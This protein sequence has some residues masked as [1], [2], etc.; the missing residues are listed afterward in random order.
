MSKL[1]RHQLAA[2][3]AEKSLSGM[4]ARQLGEET[5]AYLLAEGRTGELDSLLRD[6]MQY[7]ADNGIVEVVAVS[8]RQLNDKARRNVEAQVRELYPGAKQITISEQLDQSV[9]GGVRLELANQQL[10]LSIRS[11][12]NKFKQLTTAGE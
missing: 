7:R 5:A 8:A 1:P 9:I 2:I 10:D 12:L 3:L 4:S 11:K 6:V